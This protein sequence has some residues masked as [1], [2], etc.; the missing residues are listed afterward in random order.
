MDWDFLVLGT[1]CKQQMLAFVSDRPS[2]IP[3]LP[4]LSSI[5]PP[6]PQNPPSP[7]LIRHRL[8]NRPRL[9]HIQAIQLLHIPLIQLEPIHILVL[10]DATRRIA[11]G[12]RHPALLQ[13]VA[14]Q[15]LRRR[16]AV[17]LADADE[18]GVVGFLRADEGRVG[19]DD[20]LVP[21]AVGGDGSLLAPGVQLIPPI[22]LH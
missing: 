9:A 11:L 20:D 18:G 10:L 7:N 21:G 22:S 17:F 6:Q 3:N 15:D 4:S 1:T 14:D 8:H 13:T 5:S 12:Q 16:D 2:D 19:F